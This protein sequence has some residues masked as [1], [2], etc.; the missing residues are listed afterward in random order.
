[1]RMGVDWP[2]LQRKSKA[3]SSDESGGSGPSRGEG[4]N[5]G[6]KRGAGW[7]DGVVRSVE[8]PVRVLRL[9]LCVDE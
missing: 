6:M 9:S 7:V 4:E 1:M 3:K 2:L 8:P 5:E